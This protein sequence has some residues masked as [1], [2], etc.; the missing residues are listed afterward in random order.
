MGVGNSKVAATYKDGQTDS[1]LTA[2]PTRKGSFAIRKASRVEC[3]LTGKEQYTDIRS[4]SQ[5]VESGDVG[6]IEATCATA[7]A[8][9]TRYALPVESRGSERRRAA[10]RARATASRRQ[11]CASAHHASTAHPR[12]RA[13]HR[14][15][16]CR[17]ERVHRADQGAPAASFHDRVRER[18]L[19]HLGAQ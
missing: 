17:V 11:R 1:A 16:L 12:S 19:P 4:L 2:A 3:R 14:R 6:L 7:A 9:R 5:I 13:L 8:A 10:L 18:L 15:Q